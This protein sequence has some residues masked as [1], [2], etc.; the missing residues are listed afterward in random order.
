MMNWEIALP[1]N[2][3][4]RLRNTLLNHWEMVPASSY[5][6]V[7][8]VQMEDGLVSTSRS[9]PL[10]ERNTLTRRT[11]GRNTITIRTMLDHR[12]STELNSNTMPQNNSTVEMV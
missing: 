10:K 2:P 5:G 12:R 3:F 7:N 9:L 1:L 8:N 11:S 6:P 4:L